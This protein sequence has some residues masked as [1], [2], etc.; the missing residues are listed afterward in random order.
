M[1]LFPEYELS[2]ERTAFAGPGGQ[3]VEFSI[4][5]KKYDIYYRADRN[6]AWLYH[7]WDL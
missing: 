6:A 4:I 3:N 1:I 2:G 5:D 7:G